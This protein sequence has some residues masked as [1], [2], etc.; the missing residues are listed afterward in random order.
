MV[1]YSG[2]QSDPD[3]KNPDTGACIGKAPKYNG[4]AVVFAN[5]EMSKC[6]SS[7]NWTLVEYEF[8]TKDETTINLALQN[9][10]SGSSC[11]GTAYF[12]DIKLEKAETSNNWD[13]LAVFFKN[14]DASVPLDGKIVQ[15]R[16]SIT[17]SQINE[18][19][20]YVLDMLPSEL[21][22]ISNNKI[23]VNSIDRFFIDE[24][25]TEKDLK[26]ANYSDDAK[27]IPHG[28]NIDTK[29]SELISKA[30]D[31]YLNQ[32]NYNQILVFSPLYGID[33]GTLGWGGTKYNGVNTAS[34]R[35]RKDGG[36]KNSSNYPCATVVHEICHGLEHESQAINNNKTADF[37]DMYNYP[38]LDG[39]E[40]HIRY[41]NDTLPDG[42]KGVEPSVFYRPT[43]KYT[44]VDN[45]MST[46]TGISG[47]VVRGDINNDGTFNM[48]D[49]AAALTMCL[50]GTE[51]DAR[52][53]QAAGFTDKTSFKMSDVAG[54]LTQYLKS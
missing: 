50:S 54:L 18:I 4:K 51:L 24:T 34:I 7:S 11:K 36:F 33:G 48:L 44:L 47:A 19:N 28:Y 23:T 37:H 32:K 13:I 2:F 5:H 41:I 16:S 45:D 8:T 6:S 21:K 26:I 39:R 49:V 12:S 53:R 27:T 17:D 10:L 29:N 25:L 30:L 46:G 38:D 15:H 31:K 42:K 22:S 14:I 52:T 3:A 43:G 20:T 9:G 40:W 35:N 1:K